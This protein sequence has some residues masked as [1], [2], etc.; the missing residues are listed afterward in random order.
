MLGNIEI[1]HDNGFGYINQKTHD[2]DQEENKYE[3]ESLY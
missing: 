1:L 3:E 2:S